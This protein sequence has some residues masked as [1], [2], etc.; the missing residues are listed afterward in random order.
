M[1]ATEPD[2]AL[3]LLGFEFVEL[4]LADPKPVNTPAVKP[5]RRKTGRRV[6]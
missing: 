5:P 6:R 3:D 2:A 4:G 1:Y